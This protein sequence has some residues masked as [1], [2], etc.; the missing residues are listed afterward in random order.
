MTKS[1]INIVEHGGELQSI[2]LPKCQQK[3]SQFFPKERR[4]CY[5]MRAADQMLRLQPH[6][7][8][9]LPERGR[10]RQGER[11]S[12]RLSPPG[13]EKVHVCVRASERACCL[14]RCH[15]DAPAALSWVGSG[16]V[17][18]SLAPSLVGLLR[19][20][21]RWADGWVG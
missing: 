21:E 11:W 20:E 9:H 19:R 2:T 15:R 10:R 5:C 1:V 13:G 6:P 12:G 4:L 18:S 3:Q 16:I 7:P 17:G 8:G 14:P